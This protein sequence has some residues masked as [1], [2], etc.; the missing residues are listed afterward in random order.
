MARAAKAQQLPA[1]QPADQPVAPISKGAPLG[2]NNRQRPYYFSMRRALARAGNGDM[3]KGLDKLTSKVVKTAMNERSEDFMRAQ[4]V[5]RDTLDGKPRS[6]AE[7]EPIAPGGGFVGLAITV[8]GQA[9]I[10]VN[11]GGKR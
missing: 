5:V 4:V 2:N 7:Q 1:E 3:R 9:N 6:Q 10:Q 11:T 8:A